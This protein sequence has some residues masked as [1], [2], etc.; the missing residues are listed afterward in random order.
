MPLESD[1]IFVAVTKNIAET[2]TAEGRAPDAIYRIQA[3]PEQDALANRMG[4]VERAKLTWSLFLQGNETTNCSIAADNVISA[5]NVQFKTS[6]QFKV[7]SPWGI[8]AVLQDVSS[9]PKSGITKV[10]E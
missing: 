2:I 5:V 10:K 7:A 8:G 3:T 9:S 6:L 4:A 1:P